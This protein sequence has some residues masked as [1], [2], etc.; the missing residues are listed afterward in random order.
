MNTKQ[1][2]KHIL[3]HFVS[4]LIMYAVI[5]GGIVG[6]VKYKY[7]PQKV[8]GALIVVLGGAVLLKMAHDKESK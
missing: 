2:I 6:A 5:L 3:L 7:Q 1:L 4:R 8:M